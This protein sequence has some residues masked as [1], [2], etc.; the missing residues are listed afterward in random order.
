MSKAEYNRQ[1]RTPVLR[2]PLTQLCPDAGPTIIQHE[3]VTVRGSK[4][5]EKRYHELPLLF[6][7]DFNIQF[8][9]D[10]GLRCVQFLKKELNLDFVSAHLKRQLLDYMMN[11]PKVKIIRASKREGLIRAR[12]LGADA[13]TA[14]VLTYLDSH[15]ECTEGWLEPL[16]DRIA[17][18]PTIVVCPVIDV[19]DDTTLEYHWRDSGGVNV[20]GFDWNLQSLLVHIYHEAMERHLATTTILETCLNV[21]KSQLHDELLRLVLKAVVERRVSPGRSRCVFRGC[22]EDSIDVSIRADCA[23]STPGC[24]SRQ[25]ALLAVVLY[26]G[27]GWEGADRFT[28]GRVYANPGKDAQYVH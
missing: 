3:A 19:I 14:P 28:P 5:L 26:W 1:Y 17:R 22:G 20:G 18:D 24:T 13:A 16:L 8:D 12:L 2:A 11:Y 9:T 15:C 6:G 25:V 7:G 23:P 10:G 21:H 4:L 27:K